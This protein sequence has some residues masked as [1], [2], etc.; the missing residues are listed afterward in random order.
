MN[1]LDY[2]L[3]SLPRAT[4][5]LAGVSQG[6]GHIAPAIRVSRDITDK[7]DLWIGQKST[8]HLVRM[9]HVLV[10]AAMLWFSRSMPLAG[11]PVYANRA[12]IT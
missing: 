6:N 7:E 12:W 10:V 11:S 2:P 4:K 9:V 1:I 5:P 8:L 3:M